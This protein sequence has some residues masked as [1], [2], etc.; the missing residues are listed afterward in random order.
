MLRFSDFL[1]MYKFNSDK[2]QTYFLN[3]LK[4]IRGT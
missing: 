3:I 4:Q 1:N 2:M